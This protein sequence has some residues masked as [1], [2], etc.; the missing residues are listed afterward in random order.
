MDQEEKQR[1]RELKKLEEKYGELSDELSEGEEEEK[2]MPM[3][4]ASLRDVARIREKRR[5]KKYP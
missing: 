2:D 3:Q 4:G 5:G 1:L